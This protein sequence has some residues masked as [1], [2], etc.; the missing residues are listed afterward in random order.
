[1]IISINCG[2]KQFSSVKKKVQKKCSSLKKSLVFIQKTV[3]SHL[4][5]IIGRGIAD[6]VYSDHA[7]DLRVTCMFLCRASCSLRSQLRRYNSST[8]RFGEALDF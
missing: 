5:K 7:L 4:K 1:M 3:V 2:D 6:A 8:Y